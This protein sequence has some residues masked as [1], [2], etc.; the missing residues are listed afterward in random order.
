[1]KRALVWLK[2]DLRLHDNFVFSAAIE[3]YEEVI[4]VYCIDEFHFSITPFGT[5]KT[6]K[7]R[8]KF[9]LESLSDLK[10]S[11]QMLGSDLIVVKGKPEVELLRI[12]NTYQ[13]S[14]IITSAEIG[15][16][17]IE[18]INKVKLVLL[19]LNVNINTIRNSTLLDETDLPFGIASI[20]DIFTEFRKK[21]EKF[22]S[23]RK[24]IDLPLK[25]NT[26]SLEISSIPTL[27][28]LGFDDFT[29][30]KRAAIHFMGGESQGLKRIREF[31]F[32]TKSIA[33]YKTTRN[34]LIGENYS[35]KFSA[36]LSNGCISARRVYAEIKRYESAYGENESTYWLIFELLWRDYFYFIMQKYGNL[37]FKLGGIKIAE[38]ESIQ[39]KDD[40]FQH[41]KNA[42]TGIDFIDSNML[43][44]KLTGFMSNR[45]RQNVASYLCHN[46]K[47][48]WRYGA[49]YFEEQ[50]ID[51]DVSC[52][53]CNWAYVAGVGNDPR[54][55]RVFNIEKQANDYDTNKKYR[56]LWMKNI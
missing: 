22:S 12:V 7:F 25:I 9:L 17:E 43:E 36:W 28:E 51:Y 39:H 6:G 14:E 44:L 54:S 5:Q 47:L 16:E 20:S 49:A 34:G 42:Q 32:E 48:D 45:G 26:P 38:Q 11:L 21:V 50:L 46:L 29:V 31:I 4:P 37:F 56:T 23:I 8:A 1:M 15:A 24:P 53:W 40:L 2:N 55:N 41:W 52:N 18:T 10:S 27:K 13:I 33:T 30:D 19:S 3:K 35:S